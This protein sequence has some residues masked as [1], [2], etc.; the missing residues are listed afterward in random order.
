MQASLADVGINVTIQQHDSGTFW[1]LGD[2]KS[3][4][5]WK[6]VQMILNRFSMQPDPSFATVRVHVER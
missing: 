6:K 3:G 4:D 5:A 1:S 2:E